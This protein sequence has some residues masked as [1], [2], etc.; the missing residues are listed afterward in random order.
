M[1]RPRTNHAAT[2]QPLSQLTFR[3]SQRPPSGQR[4]I[5]QCLSRA[6]S[7][8]DVESSPAS[9]AD[10][11]LED[12]PSGDKRYNG[13][14]H[15]HLTPLLMSSPLRSPRMAG[16]T[17]TERRPPAW[18]VLASTQSA[19]DVLGSPTRARGGGESIL[20]RVPLSHICKNKGALPAS[21]VHSSS[22]CGSPRRSSV[23][24]P[25]PSA[26]TLTQPQSQRRH[27]HKLLPAS[28]PSVHCSPLRPISAY[29]QN[30]SPQSAPPKRHP[31]SQRPDVL[32]GDT[33]LRG[34]LPD[35]SLALSPSTLPSKDHTPTKRPRKDGV[36]VTEFCASTSR[37]KS[38]YSM[39][40]H[41]MNGSADSS[42]V[43][44]KSPASLRLH[45][46]SAQRVVRPHLFSA[47]ASVAE[48][49]LGSEP[50]LVAGQPLTLLLSFALCMD[51]VPQIAMRMMNIVAALENT[52]DDADPMCA[53][54][55]VVIEVHKPWRVQ[56]L[57]DDMCLLISRFSIM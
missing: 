4:S 14:S 39:W 53:E 38:D 21:S 17:P 24:A 20:V 41:C 13:P 47:Q 27:Q 26:I 22:A 15:N 10:E 12:C 25:Q 29:R 34:A 6:D 32:F 1:N 50:L 57:G 52:S 48:V 42:L 54:E 43:C 18:P 19:A 33:P 8:E 46:F 37:L 7:I 56:G 5:Q 9:L 55:P 49:L 3:L 44:L 31:L 36:T 45:V 40:W 30:V 23:L 11:V 35:H 2:L 51:V 16:S 28:P